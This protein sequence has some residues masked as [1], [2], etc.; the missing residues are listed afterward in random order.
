MEVGG[1][2]VRLVAMASAQPWLLHSMRLRDME[3]DSKA[4]ADDSQSRLPEGSSM[5]D[6][7]SEGAAMPSVS[8]HSTKKRPYCSIQSPETDAEE[9]TSLPAKKPT[10]QDVRVASSPR[11]GAEDGTEAQASAQLV[12][13]ED[14]GAGGPRQENQENVGISGLE[15][16]GCEFQL[17]EGSEDPRG[18]NLNTSPI[19]CP[20][21]DCSSLL[22]QTGNLP[23]HPR[24]QLVRVGLRGMFRG[25]GSLNRYAYRAKPCKHWTCSSDRGEETYLH[26]EA[27]EPWPAAGHPLRLLLLCGLLLPESFL[28]TG[29]VVSALGLHHCSAILWGEGCFFWSL[30]IYFGAR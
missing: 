10:L 29:L 12:A 8:S 28:Y 26:L 23:C 3:I 30:L 13:P 14:A 22:P 21:C 9:A 18:T 6:H 1:N 24:L 7:T 4:S 15:Q 19:L 2:T 27:S 17:P 11:P 20:S 25:R 16:L 5:E